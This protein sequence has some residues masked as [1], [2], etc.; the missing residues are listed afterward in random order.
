MKHF[1][2]PSLL[3]C[4]LV[5]LLAHAA[6]SHAADAAP[7][8]D[9][10]ALVNGLFD[11]AAA[12]KITGWHQIYRAHS[13]DFTTPDEASLQQLRGLFLLEKPRYLGTDIPP[14][15]GQNHFQN[16]Q[17]IW[18]DA[19]GRQLGWMRLLEG[20]HLVFNGTHLFTTSTAGTKNVALETHAADFASPEIAA[21]RKLPEPDFK[22]MIT[23][24]FDKAASC[25]ITGTFTG[26][27][28]WDKLP[29]EVDFT[30]PDARS[31]QKLKEMFLFEKPR[32]CVNT[33]EPELAY[34]KGYNMYFTWFDA[35]GKKL[36]RMLLISRD[37]LFFE[38]THDLFTTNPP[39]YVNTGRS[40]TTLYNRTGIFALPKVYGK[41]FPQ[42]RSEEGKPGR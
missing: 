41:R 32:F 30:T 25:K 5:T 2:P 16:L 7:A 33:K 22:T 28:S 14:S 26:W 34:A 21:E 13:I 4:V 18:V 6:P 8:P 37:S 40:N 35:Q 12:C 19:Q 15:L 38:D 10:Q 29:H 11:K 9:Y 17:F 23:A 31:L 3:A 36:G 20:D 27:E 39:E 1:L 42:A 24:L